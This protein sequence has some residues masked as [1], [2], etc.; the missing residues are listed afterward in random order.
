MDKLGQKGIASVVLLILLI[1][2]IFTIGLFLF[3]FVNQPRDQEIK[4][5]VAIKHLS[6]LVASDVHLKTVEGIKAGLSEL[7]YKEGEDIF[8]DFNNPK[9]DRELTKSLAKT[10]LS[11]KPDLIIGVSTTA[12]TS[13]VAA[14]KELGVNIPIVFIDVGNFKE[15]GITDIKHPNNNIT[16]LIKDDIDSGA[17]RL[18]ILKEVVPKARVIGLILNPKHISYNDI[19]AV[20]SKAA[21]NL[22]VQIKEYSASS[23][24]EFPSLIEQIKK[25]KVDGVITTSDA[26][27]FSNASI[28]AKALSEAKIPSMDLVA[29]QG[30]QSG[31]MMSYGINRFDIGK[32]GAQIVN[33]V[34]S[35]VDPKTMPI[36]FA[37]NFKLQVNEKVAQEIGVTI[38][39]SVKL[40][41]NTP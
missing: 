25:D 10:I 4:K 17:K 30:I 8:L 26:L 35:G 7:G 11:K 16:G 33:K 1:G 19:R 29:E 23:K 5:T 39:E 2:I 31:Y 9:G 28:I 15:L 32:Q 3:R 27:I 38:P 18:E 6:I 21:V 40:R 22:G 14:R 34:L 13:L 20:F 12:T 41:V 37:S 36:E 24:E